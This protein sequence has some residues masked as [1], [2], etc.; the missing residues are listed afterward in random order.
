MRSDWPRGVF[1]WEY[2]NMVVASRY[3]ACF[4]HANHGSTNLWKFSSSKLDKFTLFTHSFVGWKLGNRY[5]EGVSIFFAWADILSDK[6][7]HFVKHLFAKQELITRARLRVQDFANGKN[8]S[9]NQCHNKAFCVYSWESYSIKAI[10]NFFPVF[11]YPD[12]N[13][14]SGGFH[15]TSSPPCWWT[16][17]KR[18]LI[19]SL[20]LSTS[21]CSFHHCYLCLPR[22]HENHLFG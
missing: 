21:I 6:N 10:Q 20:C 12:L 3:F 9:Y 15:V 22:L 17:N 2:V 13:T 18:S 19:S 7:P 16:V 8:F 14:R 11:V 1:A 5:K 4:S